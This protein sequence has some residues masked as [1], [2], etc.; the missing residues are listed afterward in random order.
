[1]YSD[2]IPT[3]AEQTARGLLLNCF[4]KEMYHIKKCMF[5]KCLKITSKQQ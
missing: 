4:V 5:A 2:A 3:R 1:M